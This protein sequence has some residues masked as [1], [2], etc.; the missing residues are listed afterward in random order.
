[1]LQLI[2]YYIDILLSEKIGHLDLIIA[3]IHINDLCL[4]FIPIKDDIRGRKG[5]PVT[6]SVLPRGDGLAAASV[7]RGLLA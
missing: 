5:T 6:F 7:L 4:T 1:M 2:L 3:C